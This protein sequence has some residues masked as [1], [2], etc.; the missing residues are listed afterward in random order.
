VQP[1]PWQASP[2]QFAAHQ[3]L[4][5]SATWPAAVAQHAAIQGYL[6]LPNFGQLSLDS[7]LRLQPNLWLDDELVNYAMWWLQQRDAHMFG[8]LAPQ[9]DGVWSGLSG[10]SCH[11]FSSFFMAKLYL[12]TETFDYRQVRR[13]TSAAKLR[14]AGQA[15]HQQGVLSCSLVVAPCNL[16]NQHWTLVVADLERCRILYLDPMGVSA[17]ACSAP[18]LCFKA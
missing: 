11:F 4:V 7:L 10:V 18:Y 6:S 2:A 1:P 17:C 8:V 15:K 16:G 5:D 14:Q 12:D 3:L 13:W 9:L